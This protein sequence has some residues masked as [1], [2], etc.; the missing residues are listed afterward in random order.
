MTIAIR[1]AFGLPG[2]KHPPELKYYDRQMMATEARDFGRDYW[3]EIYPDD[4]EP[5][6]EVIVPWDWQK[7]RHEFM[8]TYYRIMYAE[9]S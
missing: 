5:L 7:A 2:D 1:K 6:A 9:T 8:A 3:S 4:P